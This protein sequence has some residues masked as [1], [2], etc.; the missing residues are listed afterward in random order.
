ML[1]LRN[2]WAPC[3]PGL[4]A[5]MFALACSGSEPAPVRETATP[6]PPPT[7]TATP[8]L[9]AAATS[10]PEPT[11]TPQPTATPRPAPTAT[12]APTATPEPTIAPTPTMPASTPT[13]TAVADGP[14]VLEGRWE[15]VNI[16]PGGIELPFVVT[17]YVSDDGLQGTMDIPS[18]GA[19]GLELSEVAFQSG[20][21]HFELDTAI[22]L[23]A[24]DGEL[25]DEVIEGDLRQAGRRGTFRLIR[26]EMIAAAAPSQDEEAPP[27]R[28]EEV[29]FA[30]GDIV[31]TGSLTLPDADGPHPAVVLISGSGAQ[32]RDAN[33]FGFKT[34]A[35]IADR[36]ARHGVAVLRFD[37]RGVGGSGGNVL[38]ATISDRAQDVNAA[39]ELLR[40]RDDI[41][42]VRIGL[43]GHSEGGMIAPL[44]AS[45]RDGVAFVVLLAAPAVAGDAIL[46]AQLV[47]ILKADGATQEQI[48]QAQ[49]QQDL[50]LRAVAT[51]EGWDEVEE[52]SRRTARQQIEALP[53]AQREAIAD[54]DLYIDTIIPEQM[55]Y[56]QSPWYKSFYEYDPVPALAGLT[57]PVLALY[58]ELDTQV[59]VELNATAFSE[60]VTGA[61]NP[62]YTVVTLT[63]ANHLF[64]EA[65]TGSL[66]E[67]AELKPEFIPGFLESILDWILRQTGG[68]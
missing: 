9:T 17:L 24:W 5:V 42:P 8:L 54:I 15:G 61:G 40:S 36:L 23:A 41:D 33:L 44:V 7:A 56:V 65:I 3:L 11:A 48:E 4:I 51:G 32:D 50:M 47:E 57:V 64:Q 16:P 43:I 52:T 39:V 28:L 19:F 22:G 30:N 14:A 45:R 59:P 25:R 49:A 35:I 63:E 38:Q 12:V 27:Y 67:Y 18:Q 1:K 29:T 10:S 55:Q 6:L 60:I 20:R 31:L 62:D 21:L 2:R 66:S 53:E 58:G 34:F 37:D 13:P 68:P 46:R 26:S